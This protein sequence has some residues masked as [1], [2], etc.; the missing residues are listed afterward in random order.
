MAGQTINSPTSQGHTHNL[1]VSRPIPTHR[2][3]PQNRRSTKRIEQ[4]GM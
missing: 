3:F 4:I 2:I 1:T